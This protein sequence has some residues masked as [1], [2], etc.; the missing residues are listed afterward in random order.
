[1]AYTLNLY[2]YIVIVLVTVVINKTMA[3][4]SEEELKLMA[5][6]F[7]GL[8]VKPKMDTP[9]EFKQWMVSYVHVLESEQPGEK[10]KQESQSD[11][12]STVKLTT[13]YI[14]KL[15]CYHGD[16]ST[17][18]QD[19][20][21]DQWRYEVD[22]LIK[23]KYADSIIAQSIRNSLRG[24]A[25]KV[26]MRLGPEASVKDILEKMESIFGSIERGESVMQE[27]YSATQGLSEDSMTWSCRLEEI[28]RKAV[29]KG[30]ATRDEQNSKLRSRY[31]NGLQQWLRDITA[32]KYDAEE[33]FDKLRRDIRLVE[34]EHEV[35]K[36]QSKMAVTTSDS[37]KAEKKDEVCELKGMI[38]QLTA[39][40]NTIEKGQQKHD[41]DWSQQ[42]TSGNGYGHRPYR[43]RGNRGYSRG[44]YRGQYHQPYQYEP[45]AQWDP[46]EPS[47]TDDGEP[48]CF[49]CRQ[50]GHLARGCR[51]LLDHSRRGL[52][53]RRPPSRGRR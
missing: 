22:C 26:I 4:P 2:L 16:G 25:A 1:M 7:K 31:Y 32:Y 35:T 17:G 24:N 36:V 5:A 48:I 53:S 18:K 40:V 33:D 12:Q 52:N 38:Q 44:S 46:M 30:V 27:F 19:I 43:G 11:I 8:K 13:H 9:E 14:P 3:E 39:K 51:V 41:Q 37:D 28:Y 45:E 42:A 10:V 6:A 49:R 29:V 50:P 47:N 15:S 21:Y 20:S 23:E 34:K